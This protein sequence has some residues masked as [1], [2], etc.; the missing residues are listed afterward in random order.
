LYNAGLFYY[1]VQWLAN[2]TENETLYIESKMPP[3]YAVSKGSSS[4]NVFT[5]VVVLLI[6]PGIL[7]IAALVVYRK[8]KHL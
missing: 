8:R 3:S 4:L 2:M 1:G 6:L 7:L 5:S